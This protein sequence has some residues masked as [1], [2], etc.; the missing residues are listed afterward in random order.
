MENVV[1]LLFLSLFIHKISQN[2]AVKR[3][4]LKEKV[5]KKWYKNQKQRA[6][7][8]RRKGKKI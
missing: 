2:K 8:L 6:K 1:F 7:K 5:Q 4:K 3:K